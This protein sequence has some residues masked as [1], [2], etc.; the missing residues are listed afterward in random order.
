[1][2]SS[3]GCPSPGDFG[4]DSTNPA[5]GFFID[6]LIIHFNHPIVNPRY[7]QSANSNC[8]IVHTP[9][10]QSYNCMA[11]EAFRLQNKFFIEKIDDI[12]LNSTKESGFQIVQ[13]YKN[14]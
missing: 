4:V 3:T 13:P 12:I 5:R 10:A 7:V 2:T 8:T 9:F 6:Y 1:M 14:Q 11:D